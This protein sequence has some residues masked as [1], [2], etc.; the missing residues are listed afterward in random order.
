MPA[1]AKPVIPAINQLQGVLSVLDNRTKRP[2]AELLGTI[3]EMVG[4]AIAVLQEPDPLRKRIGFVLLAVQQSTHV[5][6]R[7]VNGK[8]ITRVT[9]V[10]QPLYHWALEEIHS[11]AG[12]R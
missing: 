7:D 5:S 1:R 12:V 2:T 6:V 9:V 11:L 10:D 8:R 3:R 4:D